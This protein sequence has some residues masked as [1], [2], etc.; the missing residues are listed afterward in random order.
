MAKNKL[1]MNNLFG[2]F[3]VIAVILLVLS[4]IYAEWLWFDS[5]E[6]LSVFKSILFSKIAIGVGVFFGIFI[7]LLLNFFILKKR[8]E[9]TNQKIFL[10][11]ITIV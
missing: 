8:A 5:L 4:G 2:V 10:I 1:I 7:L 3:I 9:I 6:Y 11:V